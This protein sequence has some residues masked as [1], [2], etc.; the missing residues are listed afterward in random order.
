MF[1]TLKFALILAALATSAATAF[2]ADPVVV[3][4]SGS[5]LWLTGKSSMHAYHST[6]SKFDAVIRHDALAWNPSLPRGEAIETLVRGKGVKAIDVTVPVTAMKSGKDGL[7][8]NM[9][10]ALIATKH[11]E[12]RYVLSDYEVSD[13]K[14][15]DLAI[16]A[17]GKVTV[18]GVEQDVR[19]SVSATREGDTVR[20]K[21]SVPLLMTQFGIKPPTMM[22]GALKT[23]NEVVIHFDLIVG[24]GEPSVAATGGG[25]TR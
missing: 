1:R 24:S 10:K 13:G 7:D 20:L 8:K 6:A 4:Q 17:K 19:I 15:G 2:A 25:A 11:P 3:V 21:G 14:A 18:A 22:M 16:D 23:A 5:K 9:Y 12:I